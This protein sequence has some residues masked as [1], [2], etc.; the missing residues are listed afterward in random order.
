MGVTS[1]YSQSLEV[2]TTNKGKMDYLIRQSTEFYENE[3]YDSSFYYANKALF[4]SKQEGDSYEEMNACEHVWKGGG[5][6]RV[7]IPHFWIWGLFQTF[8]EILI[9]KAQ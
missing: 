8:L 4:I 6:D 3:E 5:G 9:K 1:L 2:D 7:S